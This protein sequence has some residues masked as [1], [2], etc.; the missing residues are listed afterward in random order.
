MLFLVDFC[1][2]KRSVEGATIGADRSF[3]CLRDYVERETILYFRLGVD[4]EEVEIGCIK[5]DFIERGGEIEAG[6]G[7]FE[8]DIVLSRGEARSRPAGEM[9]SNFDW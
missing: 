2:S 6:W 9:S 1:Q 3:F 5:G 8:R 4:S 7:G